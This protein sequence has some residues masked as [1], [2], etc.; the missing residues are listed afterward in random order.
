MEILGRTLSTEYEAFHTS[1]KGELKL[2]ITHEPETSPE[3]LGRSIADLKSSTARI[4]IRLELPDNA[5]S[6]VAAHELAH[7]LQDL[8]GYYKISV[9]SAILEGSGEAIVAQYLTE[10]TECIA[11]D[12][13]IAQYGLDGSYA[14]EKRY[15]VWFEALRK[16]QR[17]STAPGSGVFAARALQYI[18]GS[19]EQP[20]ERWD[21]LRRGFE[22]KYPNVV[23]TAEI[24]RDRVLACG[25]ST[26]D[27]R[28]DS[29]LILRDGLGLQGIVSLSNPLTGDLL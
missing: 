17:S 18:R 22:A 1:V 23:E 25:L 11:V 19:F 29:M 24:L 16:A 13:I 9:G 20:A 8:R 14:L 6:H 27:Q 26:V 15:D 12:Q 10:A 2:E 4:W 28:R 5:F 21:R 7:V 3:D